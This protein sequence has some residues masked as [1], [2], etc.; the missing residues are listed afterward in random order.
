[1]LRFVHR[2]SLLRAM[3]FALPLAMLAPA[4]IA[5]QP[6]QNGAPGTQPTVAAAPD[7]LPPRPGGSS[8]RDSGV[9]LI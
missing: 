4:A 8:N 6:G 7:V 2:R 1:M 5:D 3:S 9:T